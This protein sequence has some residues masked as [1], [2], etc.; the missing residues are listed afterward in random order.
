MKAVSLLSSGI[1]SPVSSYLMQKHLDIIAIHFNNEPL[2]SKEVVEKVKKL[3]EKLKIKK[4]YIIPHGKNQI[5]LMKSCNH[6][7]RCILCRRLMFKIS[8]KIAEKEKCSFLITG[9]S[10]GQVA[11]QTLSNLTNCD[12]A[13]K[14]KILRP[15]LSYDKEE[16]IK[17]AKE[18]DTYNISIESSMCCNAVPKYPKTKSRINFIKQEEEN[19]NIDKLITSSVKNAKIIKW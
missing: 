11:S 12:K 16:T 19:A 1:D 8:E 6:S 3:C 14:I 7:Y 13:V 17:I 5:S 9:E 15:L 10:L 2:T 4:L 18:I